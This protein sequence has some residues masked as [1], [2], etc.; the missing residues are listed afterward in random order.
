MAEVVVCFKCVLSVDV[1]YFSSLTIFNVGFQSKQIVLHLKDRHTIM[2]VPIYIF[3]NCHF[4][5]K[6]STVNIF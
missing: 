1:F 6:L 4:S 5:I 2:L 3:L